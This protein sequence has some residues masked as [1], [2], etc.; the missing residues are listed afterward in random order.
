MRNIAEYPMT[1]REMT[2]TLARFAEECDP[3]LV[4]D[5]RPALLELA[6]RRTARATALEHGLRALLAS[7]DADVHYGAT[8][9]VALD[10]KALLEDNGRDPFYENGSQLQTYLVTRRRSEDRYEERIVIKR[11][12]DAGW[13]AVIEWLGVAAQGRPVVVVTQAAT[14]EAAEAAFAGTPFWTKVVGVDDLAATVAAVTADGGGA[15]L[16]IDEHHRPS[17]LRIDAV[18]AGAPS[19]RIV[20]IDAGG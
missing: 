19:L 18:V 10:L 4:G 12:A 3:D 15:L 16:C 13:A 6:V 7:I 14:R 5:M 2:S 9:E 17:R 8:G 20:E 1:D 11:P